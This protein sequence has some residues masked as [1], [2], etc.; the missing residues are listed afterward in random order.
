MSVVENIQSSVRYYQGFAEALV[1]RI[2]SV[3][4]DDH[5]VTTADEMREGHRSSTAAVNEAR[6]LFAVHRERRKIAEECREMYET[7]GRAKKIIQTLARDATKNGFTLTVDD[8]EAQEIAD[9]LIKRLKLLSRLDDWCR[10]SFRDGDTFLELAV[11]RDFDIHHVTRKPTL[12]MY[13]NSDKSDRFP[14]PTRAFFYTSRPWINEPGPDVLWFAE[15]QVIHARWDHDEGNRYGRP[16]L[17]ASRGPWKRVKEGETD[18]AVRRK[19]RA[20]IKFLHTV[21]GDWGDIEKYKREN[22]A[23]L[24]NPLAAVV[25]LFVN[26]KIGVQ[27]LQ[28]D[29]RLSEIDDVKHHIKTFWLPSP[30]PMDLVGYGEDVDFSVIGHQKE[31]YD[32]TLVA[33][34]DWVTGEYLVPLLERQWMLKGIFPDDL[35][36]EIEWASKQNV[37]PDD[38]EKLAR[39]VA[40]FRA[41]GA[42]DDFIALLV[43]QF[44]PGVDP[45]L[46]FAQVDDIDD[47]SAERLVNITRGLMRAFKS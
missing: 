38:I 45:E 11:T 43:A 31:Q 17:A 37:T 36:Y 8:E 22:Q 7:D 34:Q 46:L 28:G 19:T 3:F 35:N 5:P 10:L 33:V 9:D 14:D 21:E 23:A 47:E 25:D 12:N 30:V 2:N 18:I 39:A 41:L 20:G 6:E 27:V 24:N 1:D 13:R 26:S 40:Q 4:R 29:A 15:W 32:E 16:L 42:S 44:L